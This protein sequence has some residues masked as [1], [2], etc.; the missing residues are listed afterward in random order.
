VLDDGMTIEPPFFEEKPRDVTVLFS[1]VTVHLLN[2]AASPRDW[3]S[4]LG[5][6]D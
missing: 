2:E 6:S 4:G 5:E 1:S 3:G